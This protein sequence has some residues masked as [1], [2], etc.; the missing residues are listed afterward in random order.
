ML[1]GRTPFERFGATEVEIAR[2]RLLEVA[3][4]LPP[5]LRVQVDV[6]DAIARALARDPAARPR[7][8]HEL[9]TR[10]RALR[11][12]PDAEVDA[13]RRTTVAALVTAMHPHAAGD[14]DATE[15]TPPSELPTEPE[16]SAPRDTLTAPP[17]RRYARR[18]AAVAI[19][20][21]VLVLVVAFGSVI[22]HR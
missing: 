11:P 7:D 21:S 3:P 14:W 10:L 16:E 2:R 20:L 9:A 18:V 12:R 5:L 22:L 4:R 19:A 6:D 1:A 15:V 17:R 8:A 13:T